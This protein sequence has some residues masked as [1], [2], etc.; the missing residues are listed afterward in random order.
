MENASECYGYHLN[1]LRSK[2]IF[3]PII[4]E[5]TVVEVFV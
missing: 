1:I 3:P 4:I 5:F 2:L